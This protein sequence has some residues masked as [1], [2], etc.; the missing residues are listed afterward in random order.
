M[1]IVSSQLI[2]ALSAIMAAAVTPARA[3]STTRGTMPPAQLINPGLNQCIVA[4]DNS[5]AYRMT[6]LQLGNCT[7]G[8]PLLIV[9]IPAGG[10]NSYKLQDSTTT[11]C[12]SAVAAGPLPATQV[13][14]LS[15][16]M[17]DPRQ[18]WTQIPNTQQWQNGFGFCLDFVVTNGTA[19]ASLVQN[20]CVTGGTSSQ[21][22]ILYN[23]PVPTTAFTPAPAPTPPPTPIAPTCGQWAMAVNPAAPMSA[24]G[25]NYA[26]DTVRSS[27]LCNLGG[28]NGITCQAICCTPLPTPPQIWQL[29]SSWSSRGGPFNGCPSGYTYTAGQYTTCSSGGSDCVQNCCTP[30]FTPVPQG[31]MS[32][33]EF[34]VRNGGMYNAC[35][36]GYSYTAGDGDMCYG[37][38]D[39]I[40]SCC[41]PVLF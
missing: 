36:A 9:L 3:A 32:C 10:G 26:F 30:I 22:Y 16:T 39:C 41:S 34:S 2:M 13:A 11:N 21:S 28:V 19:V 4:A 31:P 12:I 29:C 7:S 27:T 8:S 15:C 25:A 18:V 6:F 14:L 17:T 37:G 20:P 24:C 23:Q 38:S 35:G 1:K 33:S 40:D 5:A